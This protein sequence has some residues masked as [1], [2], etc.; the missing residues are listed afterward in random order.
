MRLKKLELF[1]FKSFADRTEVIFEGGV[2]CIVGPNGCGKS[3]ISDAMRWVLGERSAKLLRGSKMEDVIFNGTDFRKPVSLAEVS[4][5]IDNQDRGLPIDYNE[6]TITRRLYRSGES[7]YLIN[8]TLCRLKDI[9]DLILDT[10]IGS[11]SYSMIEQ[12]R[13][14]YILNAD[15]EERRFLIEEAAGISKYKV[16]KEEAIRKL[17]RTEENRL[18]LNDIIHEVQKN[19]QYAERQAKRAAKYQEEFDK[20]KNLETKKAFYDLGLIQAEKDS[21]GTEKTKLAGDTSAVE[22]S[23]IE[24]RK[25]QQQKSED[26]RNI[27]D[28][29]REAETERYQLQSKIDQI[30]QTLKFHQEKRVEMA[31]RSG[32]I[33]Q[34]KMQLEESVVQ[35]A[36]EISSKRIEIDSLTAAEEQARLRLENAEKNLAEIEARLEGLKTRLEHFKHESF[37]A[38]TQ[39]SK[40]RNE[41]HR[42]NAF[43]E[44]SSQQKRKQ[45]A[46]AERLREENAQW[47][48]KKRSCETDLTQ[49]SE[50]LTSLNARKIECD[51]D[52]TSTQRNLESRKESFEDRKREQHEKKTRHLMLAEIDQAARANEDALLIEGESFER[53]LAKSLRDIFTVEPGFEWALEAALDSFSRSLVADDLKT[54]EILLGRI[55][56]QK[57]APIGLLIKHET[58]EPAVEI[59][60]PV[61]PRITKSLREV[62]QVRSSYEQLFDSF[63][64]QIFIVEAASAEALLQDLLPLAAIFRFISEDG[65][66]IG[67]HKRVFYRN[68][69]VSSENNLFRRQSEI[70]SLQRDI[71]SLEDSLQED[72]IEIETAQERLKVII[73]DRETIDAERMSATVQ[74]ESL[75]SFRINL[76]ER[77]GSLRREMDLIRYESEE[78]DSQYKDAD[79]RKVQLEEELSKAEELEQRLRQEQE[80]LQQDL[81]ATDSKKSAALQEFA[82]SKAQYSH[83]EERAHLLKASLEIMEDHDRR[84]RKRIEELIQEASSIVERLEQLRAD[85]H[86]LEVEQEK[87]HETRRET[88]IAL[89]LIRQEKE[90]AEEELT[91]LQQSLQ[92]FLQRQQELQSA[93][94]QYDMKL[95]DLGFQEKTISERMVQTYRIQIWDLKAE[96]FPLGD[97]VPEELAETVTKL[98][99]KVESLGTVNLLAIEEYEELKQRFDFLMTQQKDLDEAREQLMETIRKIN[100]TTKSLFEETFANVQK[101]FSEYYQTLFRG[102]FA[103]LI[104]VDETNPLES[105]I[106]IMVRPPGKKNQHI[107]LL[108][109]G[110][111]ALTAIAL[112]FALFKIKPSP[113][114][115]LDE[116]DAPLDE[117]NVDRFLT[118]LKTFLQISQFIIV[119]HN[120]KTI[121]MG[122]SLYGVTM[123]EAGVSKLVSVKVNNDAP[124]SPESTPVKEEKTS[125]IEEEPVQA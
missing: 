58:S 83:I 56:S 36:A 31:N 90:K 102:G 41:H 38:A 111:K 9:Q 3:N 4:L 100:R 14:D 77:L 33:E 67:P 117:A 118:V 121:A 37:Q 55:L 60:A 104:L 101:Q 13:I 61:H 59:P 85:D 10:G 94:H 66:V 45:E 28:R 26:L 79:A 119:T 115:V 95:M 92:E 16:K 52:F 24:T 81:S 116:V 42:L 64:S 69:N 19:I 53:S 57:A 76:E 23:V 87:L 2:T 112:L 120:R 105:G 40:L 93:A 25:S 27:I 39:T 73:A 62:V 44:S 71:A 63:L 70:E 109:G 51:E 30:Q 88:D 12:G 89:E 18:R 124:V 80:T 49:L 17:E 5:T 91:A 122:D 108:S 78:L 29:Y 1:G 6:V 110:E 103:Q 84:N 96:D 97:A 99:E 32:Q 68:A 11:S 50:K 47:E 114:C 107:S 113:F 20:L 54:A 72:Q 98:K 48:T 125:S 82:E 35:S 8:K 21:I 74:K 46:G 106:D 75:D 43:L 15:A 34:E 7:E 123:Q 22:N 65:I 86:N